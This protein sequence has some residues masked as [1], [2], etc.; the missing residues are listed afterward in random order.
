MF[1]I[2][3]KLVGA[4]QPCVVQCV[5]P[6]PLARLGGWHHTRWSFSSFFPWTAHEYYPRSGMLITMR[7]EKLLEPLKAFCKEGKNP[8]ALRKPNVSPDERNKQKFCQELFTILA[9]LLTILNVLNADC[10]DEDQPNESPLRSLLDL[11][12]YFV[13]SSRDDVRGHLP[14]SAVI[15]GTDMLL[16]L[17]YSRNE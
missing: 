7:P 8:R 17:Q 6:L 12:G 11:L 15:D 2:K 5:G 16:S 14:L 4:T 9:E 3:R 10:S 1:R 13:S